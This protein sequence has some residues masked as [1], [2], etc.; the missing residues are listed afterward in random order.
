M[1]KLVL[2]NVGKDGVGI[3]LH[4]KVKGIL[5]KYKIWCTR[6]AFAL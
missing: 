4:E 2:E 3:M 6:W 5:T 1:K